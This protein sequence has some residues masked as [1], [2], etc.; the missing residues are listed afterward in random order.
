MNESLYFESLFSSELK[1]VCSYIKPKVKISLKDI[2]DDKRFFIKQNDDIYI[3]IPLFYVDIMK[4][5]NPNDKI[6]ENGIICEKN[7]NTIL[8]FNGDE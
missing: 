2:L 8:I 7:N 6:N 5:D 4:S 1:R 3:I